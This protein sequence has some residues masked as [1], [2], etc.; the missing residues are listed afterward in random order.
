[1]TGSLYDLHAHTRFSDG[2][3]MEDMVSAAETAGCDG[4]GLTDH[5]ILADDDFGRR[6]EYDLVNTYEQRR[7]RIE[8]VRETTD[9]RVFDAVEISYVPGTAEEIR[10][11]LNVAGFDYSIGAVH[12]AGEHDYTSSSSYA[13]D[14]ESAIRV[15]VD[16][17][18]DTLVDM[19]ESDLFDI[20]AHLDLPER[21]DVL[22][23]ATTPDHYRAVA[24][25]V[26]ESRSI[27]EVNAGRVF[28]SLGRVHPNPELLDTFT[29]RQIEFVFG[30]DSHTPDEIRRRVPYL[31]ELFGND[32]E[33][34]ICPLRTFG[35]ERVTHEGHSE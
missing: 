35:V 27:P 5:C 13:N 31:R 14:S 10:S 7:E 9:I 34:S 8:A 19:I 20:V 26:A 18:Y 17:Y 21:H 6:A 22:R 25:A 33:L 4:I 12:F 23:G 1:M 30:T 29:D 24:D 3:K 15:A 32:P 28:R 16:E 11:F 2:S